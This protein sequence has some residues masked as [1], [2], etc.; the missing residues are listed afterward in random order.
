[1]RIRYYGLTIFSAFLALMLSAVPNQ[2]GASEETLQ[3][4][5]I[6]HSASELDYPP[7][8]IIRD[9]GSA[10][11][12][13]VELL[14][15]AAEAVR[16]KVDFKVGTWNEIKNE[17]I[18]GQLD[19]LP[20]VSYSEERDKLMDFTAPYLRMNGT[21]FVRKGETSIRTESD[22]KDKEVIVMRGD[23]AHEY[24]T[25][26]KLTDNIILTDS[27][28]EAMEMLSAGKKDAVIVQYL[29]GLQL[30]K[31]LGIS[32][33]VAV[34]SIQ[35]LNLKPTSEP[36]SDFEQKFCIAVR[37]GDDDLLSLLNE[38][39]SLVIASGEY[40]ELYEKWFGPILPEEPIDLAALARYLLSI[41]LPFIAITLIIG[42]WLLK[43]EVGRKTR[44]L[45]EQI[46]ISEGATLALQ[47]SEK[48]LKTLVDTLPDMVWLKDVDG[49]YLS[50]NDRFEKF[51]GAKE[52]EIIG[53]TD[54]DF[55]DK[56]L[57]DFFRENDQIAIDKGGPSKN[58]EEVVFAD[59]GHLEV[60]ETIKTP[61]FGVNGELV[62]VLG[63]GRDVTDRKKTEE[64]LQAT[65]TRLR[66]VIN[67]SPL[68]ISEVDLNGR[69]LLINNAIAEVYQLPKSAVIGKTI[70]QLLPIEVA[71]I[72]MERLNQVKK[73]SRPIYVEDSISIGGTEK[74]Y[75]TTLFPLFDNSGNLQSV[76]TI[77]QDVTDRKLAEEEQ[78]KLKE[79][80]Q[81]AH[82]MESIGRLAGGVAHDYNN[83][84]AV[85]I[86]YTEFALEK[87][88]TNDPL[89]GDLKQVLKAAQRSVDITRQLLAFARQQTITP[90]VVDFNSIVESM[91]KML[92]RLIGEDI[93]VKWNPGSKLWPTYIDPAQVDQ[94]LANLCINA[95]DAISGNG[96]I[97]I[98][99]GVA[100]FDEAYCKR[101]LGFSAGEYVFL[102]ISD[103]GS[104]MDKE[105]V[106]NIFE[107]FFTTKD[108]DKGTGLG[109]S[110]VYGIVKQNKGFIN[111]YSELGKGTTIKLYLPRYIGDAEPINISRISKTPKSH[112]ETV[113]LVEDE[114]AIRGM[115]TQMLKRLGY[116]VLAADTPSQALALAKENSSKIDL[117]FS[118]VI[119]P[120]MN[121]RDLSNQIQTVC[122]DIKTLFMSGY[123]ANVIAHHG[124][125]DEG[126]NFIQ[127][128]FS[129]KDL[130]AKIR[131]VFDGV[132]GDSKQ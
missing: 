128:P 111:V 45:K 90:K 78:T 24:I 79:Q 5:R 92:K 15:A 6:I 59:D 7:F 16:I 31:Q 54:Y 71:Q 44:A 105:T 49:R 70:E 42:V 29:V 107:P 50:C 117:L 116:N 86:G 34:R 33:I 121:G 81:Q 3:F 126:M 75:T 68:M 64:K 118:D 76:A 61:M 85:I 73:A 17:L 30:L 131:Y 9:D 10:D 77:A 93:E 123:T 115:A 11:G 122:P 125:L 119:M 95:R 62:G 4:K 106:N 99:T 47:T 2:A 23:T 21:I 39:L 91:L 14:T 103:D 108:M 32:N 132:K 66:A 96:N 63:I 1:M 57:A 98:E 112:G 35:E 113:L 51:F 88:Q 120:E 60:L 104:G 20:L 97:I 38:G 12:F 94:I 52:E 25:R 37:E 109:L 26:K 80:L 53:K 65:T 84:L 40:N 22:L 100:T 43:R 18:K 114:P 102:A 56:E 82:K 36:L 13:S 101:H 89:H 27:Y 46:A 28:E 58:E 74:N 48:R 129:S 127:K 41:V 110:T 83:M 124:I 55:V 67:N 87:L 19:A 69:Y 8:S 130:G 72:F